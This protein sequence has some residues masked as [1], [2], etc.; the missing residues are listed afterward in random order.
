M[1]KTA[2]DDL[3]KFQQNAQR[4]STLLKA[5]SNEHRLMVLCQLQK[6]EKSVG[7]LESVIGLSQS[8]LSQ[9]LAKMRDEGIV[10]TRRE[11]QTIWYRIADPRIE[12]L[13]AT[14]YGLY[15][16]QTNTRKSA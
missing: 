2:M 15:C 13:F 1:M 5:M 12:R 3:E 11:S 9:H 8:A 6:G 16:K 7:E 14:L 10:A 4:A